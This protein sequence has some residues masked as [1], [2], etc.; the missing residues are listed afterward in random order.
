M[1]FVVAP[2][3]VARMAVQ[4]RQSYVTANN[5]L[6]QS[7]GASKLL[8]DILDWWLREIPNSQLL[9]VGGGNAALSFENKDEAKR[10]IGE[11]SRN[12]VRAAPGAR[13]V[14]G[15]GQADDEWEAFKLAGDDLDRDEEEGSFGLELGILPVTRYCPDTGLAANQYDR[16]SKSWK[17]AEGISKEECARK[18]DR[19]LHIIPNPI[20]SI[21]PSSGRHTERK[22]ARYQQEILQ[23]KFRFPLDLEHLGM[24]A[25][26]NQIAVVHCDGNGIGQLWQRLMDGR[27]G[28]LA[29]GVLELSNKLADT[30]L[31]AMAGMMLEMREAIP[32]WKTEEILRHEPDDG[33][34]QYLPIRP[35]VDSGDDMTWICAG[36]LGIGSAVRFCKQ[37]EQAS[38]KIFGADS[39]LSACAG[40]AIVPVG[41]PFR[42]AYELAEDLCG[43][44]KKQRKEDD[45]KDG[46]IDYQIVMEGGET[47][48]EKIR[49]NYRQ[50]L[51]TRP[52]SLS[53]D[54]PECESRWRHFKTDWE[55]RGRGRAKSMLEAIATSYDRG[56]ELSKL[57]AQ[58]QYVGPPNTNTNDW[59]EPL[60]LIDF[61]VEW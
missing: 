56:Q 40:V 29:A 3:V 22:I 15:I 53:V 7:V 58:Q 52:F 39:G 47:S 24:R 33:G 14:A 2:K 12:W 41:F 20:P 5:R 43:K 21:F 46:Y 25:A 51:I 57:Y 6:L 30:A 36:R 13:L 42:R 54:W 45:S 16:R 35:L 59:F 11:W 19:E 38:R 31:D 26:E 44:A 27:Q 32:K 60:E 4:S 1:E 48:V 10:S 49:A 55:T 37:F 18:Y 28:P 34:E 23:R 17:S 61:H 9:Y 8:D 50:D